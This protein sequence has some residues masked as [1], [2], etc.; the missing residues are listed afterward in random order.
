M[1][2]VVNLSSHFYSTIQCFMLSI[3][4]ATSTPPLLHVVNLSSHFY[5]TIQCFMLSISLATST[6]PYSASY[7][8]SNPFSS[9]S[10]VFPF[11]SS[12]SLLV[13][14]RISGLL[15]QSS[16]L[17]SFLLLMQHSRPSSSLT[18]LSLTQMF[19]FCVLFILSI[20]RHIHISNAYIRFSS[21]LS[22]QNSLTY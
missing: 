2:H 18:T 22:V 8:Q 4:L 20:L 21:F 10:L 7:C 15:L 19:V 12:P 5:S 17:A 1:V 9:T 6:P 3:S 14:T 11:F 13:S 16:Y